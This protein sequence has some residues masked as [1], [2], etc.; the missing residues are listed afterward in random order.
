VCAPTRRAAQSEHTN[1]VTNMAKER[2]GD[3]ARASNRAPDDR[4][5]SGQP[6]GGA[7]RRD[8]VG[9]GDKGVFPASANPDEIPGDAT[10]QGMASWGQG[11]RGAAG[12]E[13]SGGSE[14]VMR[15]GELLGGLTSGPSGAPTIDLHGG[16]RP[17]SKEELEQERTRE[18][19]RAAEP[20]LEGLDVDAKSTGGNRGESGSSGSS[21]GRSSGGSSRGGKSSR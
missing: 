5:Q 3:Q 6:G 20:P 11:E 18:A 21:S 13:E 4:E 10:P 14:L 8:D 15:E 9:T 1:E 12:Y 19:Q 2:E 7:G 16:G 17:P